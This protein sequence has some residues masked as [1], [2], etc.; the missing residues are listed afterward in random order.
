MKMVHTGTQLLMVGVNLHSMNL[1]CSH[2]SLETA[3]TL[4]ATTDKHELKMKMKIAEYYVSLTGIFGRQVNY[5][6]TENGIYW[7]TA[8]EPHHDHKDGL[9][10]VLNYIFG[11][12]RVGPY[13]FFESNNT[14][15]MMTFPRN[16]EM[17]FV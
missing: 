13:T 14:C 16:I 2:G 12:L 10:I 17:C 5:M 3:T 7:N 11:S 8:T 15:K 6:E 9:S 4:T 1:T